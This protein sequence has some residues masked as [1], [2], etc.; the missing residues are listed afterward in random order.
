MDM[1]AIDDDI[2]RAE[3]NALFDAL[4]QALRCLMAQIE[5]NLDSL[6]SEPPPRPDGR[7]GRCASPRGPER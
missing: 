7:N 1:Q 3:L 5:R 6:R 4:D 2:T